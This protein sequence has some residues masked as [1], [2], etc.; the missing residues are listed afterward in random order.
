MITNLSII[1]FFFIV[2]FN[3][4]KTTTPMTQVVARQVKL[5]KYQNVFDQIKRQNWVMAIA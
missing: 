4:S 3:F 1:K 5:Q 2:L